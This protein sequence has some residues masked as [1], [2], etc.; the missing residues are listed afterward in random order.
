MTRL[1]ALRISLIAFLALALTGCMRMD[2]ALTVNDDDTVGGEMI[3][4]VSE[5]MLEMTG[6]SADSFTEQLLQDDSL[7]EEAE[8]EEYAQDG[9]VGARMLLNDVPLEEFQQNDGFGLQRDGD[10][11]VFNGDMDTA[12]A[13]GADPEQLESMTDML[14]GASPEVNITVTFPGEV[15][16]TN[17]TADG[18]TVSWGLN[19]LMEL[20]TLEARAEADSGLLS[21]I[22]IW[23]VVVVIVVALAII[24]GLLLMLVRS[25]RK[26]SPAAA[27]AGGGAYDSGTAGYAAGTWP[28]ATGEGHQPT[29]GQATPEQ[30]APEQPAPGDEWSGD[31]RRGGPDQPPTPPPPPP[32][33]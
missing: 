11:Y 3:I 22:P 13:G 8:V 6:E 9:F 1:R 17:G 15:T 21:G 26:E 10:E 31:E 14:G 33:A 28:V 23:A 20:D 12:G 2:V 18:D 16:E 4:A 32:P 29:P 30:P 19:E 24:A 7:P 5:A 27:T 25:Q